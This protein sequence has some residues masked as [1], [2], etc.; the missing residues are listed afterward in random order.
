MQVFLDP[1]KGFNQ[2]DQKLRMKDINSIMA[3]SYTWGMGAAL[4]ERSK[5]FFDTFIKDNFKPA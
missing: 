5:D 3:F 2:T 4:D 1:A